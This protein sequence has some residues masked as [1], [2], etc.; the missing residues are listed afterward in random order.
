MS[1][2]T[3]RTRRVAE[4]V[5]RELAT[6][7]RDEIR[8]PR[9][10]SVTVSGV[11]LARDLGHAR[12]FMTVLGAEAAASEEAAGILNRA[13]GFLRREL[14]RRVRLRTVPALR[15]VHDPSFDRGAHLTSLIDRVVEEDDAHRDD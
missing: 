12:V 15:F 2:E 4:Q 3:P 1:N 7:I 10:G 11:E 5:Q 13:S 8:D 14:G 9:I 6:I